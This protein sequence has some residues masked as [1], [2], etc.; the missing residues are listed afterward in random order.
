MLSGVTGCAIGGTTAGAGNLI[1]G[2]SIQGVLISGGS[3]NA[4]QGN[5]IGVNRL[6]VNG[7]PL[8]NGQFG[9]VINNAS[10]NN[11][12]G[13]TVAG[14]SNLIASNPLGGVIVG[15]SINDN[16]TGNRIQRNSIFNNGASGGLGIDLGTDGVTQNDLKDQDSSGP[17]LRRNFPLISNIQ[18]S[19]TTITVNG[20][21]D[22]TNPQNSTVDLYA[23]A[24]SNPS[25]FG[26]GG[27][28]IGST[29]PSATGDWT[30]TGPVAVTGL[31]SR[32]NTGTA[33]SDANVRKA[34][35]PTGGLTFITAMTIDGA[36]NS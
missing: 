10:V 16:S 36:G 25:G 22:T 17:N 28:Y 15:S 3:G 4:V 30:F 32:V 35:L 2:N 11:L 9:L 14:S 29:T 19:G 18:V 6:G 20:I 23:N 26:E 27:T 5:T 13:G 33:D 34:P 7:D 21:L 24:T 31:F 8:A 12:I 1:S